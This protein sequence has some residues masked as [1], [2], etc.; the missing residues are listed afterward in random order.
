MSPQGQQTIAKMAS[1]LASMQVTRLVANGYT[2]NAPIG[3]ALK[4]R[5]SLRT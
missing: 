3:A 5:G 1:Q 2:D 4:R